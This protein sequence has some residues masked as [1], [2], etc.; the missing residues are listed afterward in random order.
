MP[1]VGSASTL[2]QSALA[3]GWGRAQGGCSLCRAVAGKVKERG[4]G[5][6]WGAVNPAFCFL[7]A[8]WNGGQG[9]AVLCP[10]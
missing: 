8:I 9:Q 5:R 1:Q 2:V 6:V 10:Y 4:K 7:G 3:R